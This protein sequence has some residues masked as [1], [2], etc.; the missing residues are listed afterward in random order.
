M[1]KHTQKKFN[2]IWIWG[3][4]NIWVFFA[5]SFK[6]TDFQRGRVDF[7]DIVI[8]AKNFEP[9][10]NQRP[11]V[12]MEPGNRYLNQEGKNVFLSLKFVTNWITKLTCACT[13]YKDL[14]VLY[15]FGQNLLYELVKTDSI[16]RKTGLKIM[17]R[18]KL[19]DSR[20]F[21]AN[22]TQQS[23]LAVVSCGTTPWCKKNGCKKCLPKWP[24]VWLWLLAQ[25][26]SAASPFATK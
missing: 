3:Q 13:L 26:R 21:C 14:T 18:L 6:N 15:I 17:L 5:C 10:P 8:V 7:V 19:K 9:C 25:S 23:F 24:H 1:D 4:L 11:L 16:T 22:F 12:V 20:F 2:S